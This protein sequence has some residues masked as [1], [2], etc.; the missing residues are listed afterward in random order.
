MHNSDGRQ[1]GPRSSHWCFLLSDL[2]L[3][4]NCNNL[5]ALIACFIFHAISAVWHVSC[6]T[7]LWSHQTCQRRKKKVWC[8]LLTVEHSRFSSSNLPQVAPKHGNDNKLW[9]K[10]KF[11]GYSFKNEFL[12]VKLKKAF[13]PC[14]SLHLD[15]CLLC[16]GPIFKQWQI[17]AQGLDWD[18]FFVSGE[19]N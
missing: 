3:N 8:D 15:L 2:G 17:Q 14:F 7:S 11:I 10:N 12:F 9:P 4:G 5:S 19:G 18:F 6:C 16:Y 1:E 13:C